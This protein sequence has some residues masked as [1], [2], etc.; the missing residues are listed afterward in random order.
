MSKLKTKKTY[1]IK[2]MNC[3]SCATMIE[4][5]L[6]ENGIKASCSFPKEIIEV[7]INGKNDDAKIRTIVENS[8]YKLG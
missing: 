7:E 1:K 3:A 4:L 2:G 6:E 5:D 8:G